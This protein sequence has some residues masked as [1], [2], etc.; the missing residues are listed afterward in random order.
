MNRPR[1]PLTFH[2]SH[3][4]LF[5]IWLA[6]RIST[7]GLFWNLKAETH[8]AA[9]YTDLNP[10]S[11]YLEQRRKWV[12]N[13]FNK[14]TV[15]EITEN[16]AVCALHFRNDVP[17]RK[18]GRYWA[19]LE[20][21]LA[22]KNDAPKSQRSTPA[23]KG[24]AT[25]QSHADTRRTVNIQASKYEIFM[26]NDKFKNKISTFHL[27]LEERIN[28]QCMIAHSSEEEHFAFISGN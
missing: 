12:Q 13:I 28:D 17:L 23:P 22:N 14:I 21:P 2:F 9:S 15:E 11:T 1:L 18:V 19:P 24:R 8:I 4:H 5:S 26:E 6:P 7:G 25:K 20:S 10:D 16:H 3:I 27:E